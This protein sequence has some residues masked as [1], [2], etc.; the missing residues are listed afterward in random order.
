MR[1]LFRPLYSPGHDKLVRVTTDDEGAVG[2]HSQVELLTHH[3]FASSYVYMGY[4]KSV[5]IKD[6][7][8][9]D[10]SHVKI[11]YDSSSPE[12][13][14]ESTPAVKVDCGTRAPPPNSGE[15]Q[16][17]LGDATAELNKAKDG[18]FEGTDAVIING[19]RGYA[20]V[21]VGA[22]NSVVWSKVRWRSDNEL[23]IVYR[24][25]PRACASQ[26]GIVVTCTP[27]TAD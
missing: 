24:G 10:D 22:P 14:C 11:L 9:I 19:Q 23:E 13:D 16:S 15:L 26:L 7:H 1:V 18:S 2:G 3:G 4:W 8:W 27:D 20:F 6:V 17:P 5:D 21:Y 12:H 25:K